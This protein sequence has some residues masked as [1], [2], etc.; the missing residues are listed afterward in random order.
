MISVEE[1][2]DNYILGKMSAEERKSFETDLN[3]DSEL[4]KEYEAIELAAE[5]VQRVAFL[6]FIEK[7]RQERVSKSNDN[8]V[9]V[10]CLFQSFRNYLDM[11]CNLLCGRKLVY[12]LSFVVLIGFVVGLLQYS[13]ISTAIQD[14]P[15]SEYSGKDKF[16]SRGG[17]SIDAILTTA[18]T[19]IENNNTD[20]AERQ[21]A[22]VRLLTDSCLTAPIVTDED[23]YSHQVAVYYQQYI[24]WCTVLVLMKQGKVLNVKK[25]LMTIASQ[26]GVY[27]DDAR[28]ILTDI[29]H[30]K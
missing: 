23:A 8:K 9:K 11:T 4:R 20:A 26:G 18:Y 6:Q 15:I 16:I 14:I 1:R 7:C 2:I 21:L 17:N 12:G 22:E 5:S 28:N 10:S 13:Q 19:N 29:Y 27:A 3:V 25:A 30:S 24:D